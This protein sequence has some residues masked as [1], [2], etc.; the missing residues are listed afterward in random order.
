MHDPPATIDFF[1]NKNKP[2]YVILTGGDSI[3]KAFGV[4]GYPAVV[5]IDK[6]GK[7]VYSSSGLFEK[8][9]EAAIVANLPNGN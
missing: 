4:E 9:L 3:A 8:D 6:N 7:V 5:L 1:K 2:E